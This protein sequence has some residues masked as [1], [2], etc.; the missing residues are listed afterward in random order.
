MGLLDSLLQEIYMSGLNYSKW[1]HGEVSDDEDDTHPNIDTPS[2]F[3]WRHEARVQRMEDMKGKTDAVEAEKKRVASKLKEVQE[4]VKKEE[5]QGGDN[6]TEMKKS[7]SEVEKAAKDVDKKR[8]ELE[9]EK[10]KQPQNVDTLSRDG[11]SKTIMNT[12]SKPV[13]ENLTEEEREKKMKK[14]VKDNQKLIKEYGMIKKF[15]DSKKF[16]MDGKTHLASEETANYLVIWCLDLEMEDKHELMC[17]VA[18]QCICMQ[19]LLELAKQL[20]CDPRACIS[21]F[22]TKIQVADEEYKA[23]FYSEL[24]AFKQRIVKRAKEKIEEAMEEERLERLGPGG[25]DPADVFESLPESM[26]KCF[27]SQ[28]IGL[29]QQVI[30]ELPE[31]EARY[32]MKRCVD[33]GLWCP[34]QDDPTTSTEDGFVKKDDEEE[35]EEIY[36]EVK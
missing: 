28:D 22:F 6:L 16:L 21:S 9:D 5:Q 1:D 23:A 18:H 34:S 33:S 19:Y 13:E 36:D 10:K 35:G 11:F 25:L 29:L 17:H 26:R 4:R 31:E 20:E 30:K 7:L 8:R 15:D 12:A 27:E 32:H 3:K 14:F 24:D 2:L